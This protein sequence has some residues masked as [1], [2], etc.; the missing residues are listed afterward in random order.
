MASKLTRKF[1]SVFSTIVWAVYPAR[2]V[3]VEDVV[4]LVLVLDVD[5]EPS[6]MVVLVVG[7]VVVED[8]V[9]V[10][11][12]EEAFSG[13]EILFKPGERVTV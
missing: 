4:V 10:V 7:V 3:V 9:V 13:M 11:G 8:V 6:V 2:V 5:A 1:P 12:V